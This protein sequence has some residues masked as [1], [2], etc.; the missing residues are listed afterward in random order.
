MQLANSAP[1]KIKML[2]NFNRKTEWAELLDSI[3]RAFP[4][5]DEDINSK[6]M[7]DSNFSNVS[8]TNRNN[9]GRSNGAGRFEGECYRCHQYGHR[10]FDCVVNL[11]SYGNRGSYA[12]GAMPN[13]RRG[14]PT[15]NSFRGNNKNNYTGSPNNS[16]A[17]SSSHNSNESSWRASQ[18]NYNNNYN[19]NNN[20]N[21]QPN[22]NSTATKEFFNSTVEDDFDNQSQ[23]SMPS[24]IHSNSISINDT[25]DGHN[26]QHSSEGEFP[27]FGLQN[28]SIHNNVTEAMEMSQ[29]ARG[30][31]S[32][33]GDLLLATVFA[34]VFDDKPRE[35]KC[36]IDGGSTHS[37]ISPL[38]ISFIGVL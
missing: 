34:N 12:R 32:G 18:P 36:L 5:G 3:D 30:S 28:L 11:N 22:V 14:G 26:R 16:F 17:S 20:R 23:Y 19:N 27:W 25:R 21:M 9:R 7:I 29:Y 38:S 10:Q 13:P 31:A 37:F 24:T 2:I 8:S 33:D 1:E 15:N 4:P 35:M 6:T